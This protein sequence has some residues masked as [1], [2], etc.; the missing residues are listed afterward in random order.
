M[1]KKRPASALLQYP[2]ENENGVY[3]YGTE[4][5]NEMLQTIKALLL[6]YQVPEEKIFLW[7]P[8]D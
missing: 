6:S 3:H 5:S 4:R 2:Y 7:N 1:R 8:E